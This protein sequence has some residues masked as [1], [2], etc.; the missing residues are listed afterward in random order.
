[1]RVQLHLPAVELAWVFSQARRSPNSLYE[2]LTAPSYSQSFGVWRFI[3]LLT[4]LTHIFRGLT[5]YLPSF[6][7]HTHTS[8][9]VWRFIFLLT[10]L[11]H[12]FRGLT[13]YLPSFSS[14]THLPGFDILSSFVLLSHTSSGVWHFIF[15]RSPLTHIFRGLTFYLPSYSSHTHLPGFDILSSFLLLS[16]TSSGVWHFIFLG[17]ALADSS[18]SSFCVCTIAT[19]GRNKPVSTAT[20]LRSCIRHTPSIVFRFFLQTLPKLITPLN[21][22]SLSPCSCSRALSAPS[23]R[24]GC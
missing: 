6:S 19:Q 22:H 1:M 9:G 4:P 15:L 20:D 16:H 7:S 10:P 24:F 5:F 18:S 23:E 3:F 13:F 17:S 2:S 12:I 8:F 14:H 11:T 21:L